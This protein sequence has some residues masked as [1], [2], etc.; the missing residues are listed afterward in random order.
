MPKP[1]PQLDV[2]PE[3]AKIQDSRLTA[4]A[5]ELELNAAWNEFVDSLDKLASEVKN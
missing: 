5:R 3:I 1:N 2:D 4:A